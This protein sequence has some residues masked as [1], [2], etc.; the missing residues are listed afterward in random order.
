MSPKAMTDAWRAQ[1]RGRATPLLLLVETDG[2]LFSLGPEG[3]HPAS[4]RVD[5]GILDAL[6]LLLTPADLQETVERLGAVVA[7]HEA[8]GDAPPGIRSAGLFTPHFLFARLPRTAAWPELAAQAPVMIP[9]DWRELLTDLGYE[10]R[11]V[12][13]GYLATVGE[14]EVAVVRAHDDPTDLDAPIDDLDD[15]PYRRLGALMRSHRLSSGMLVARGT[16]RLFATDAVP[17]RLPER[18]LELRLDRLDAAQ[19]PYLGVLAPG[20][21]GREPG[22]KRLLADARQ[23]GVELKEGVEQQIRDVALPSLVRGLLPF[24]GGDPADPEVRREL[25]DAGMTLLFRLVFLL[26]AESA[27]FL[28]VRS[29][30][31]GP[32]SLSRRAAEARRDAPT[33]FDEA[34]TGLWDGVRALVNAIRTGNRSW[35]VSAYNGGLFAPDDFP[36][37][38]LLERAALPDAA[39]GPALVALGYDRAE[40]GDDPP[41]IDWAGLGVAHIGSIYEGLLHLRLAYAERNMAY[42]AGADRYELAGPD[43]PVAQPAGSCFLVSERGGRKAGGVYYTQELFVDHLVEGALAPPLA[44]HLERVREQAAADEDAAASSLLDFAVIDPAMGSGHFLVGALDF[45]AAEIGAFLRDVPLAGIARRIE[46]LRDAAVVGDALPSTDRQLL[47]RLLVKHCVFGVDRS[48]MAVELAKIS[49]WLSSFVPGLPLSVLDA[50]LRHGDSLIGVDRIDRVTVRL[51]LL[52]PLIERPLGEAVREVAAAAERPDSTLDEVAETARAIA[53]ADRAAGTV[54]RLL[55]AYTA[56]AFG[57]RGASDLIDDHAKARA[58]LEGGIDGVGATA[59]AV[60]ALRDQIKFLHWPLAFPRVFAREN[61]GFDAV[62]GNPPWNEVTVERTGF[63]VQ[64]DPG[65]GSVRTAADREQRIAELLARFPELLNDYE[66]AVDHAERLRTFFRST[67]G[68]YALQGAGDLDLYELFCERYGA[69]LRRGG[70]FGVVLPRSAFYV[71]GTVGFRRWLFAVAPPRRLD[72]VLNNRKWAFPIHPQYTIA[73]V[74]GRRLTFRPDA[75]VELSGPHA[76]RTAFEERVPVPVAHGALKRWTQPSRRGGSRPTWEVPLLPAAAARDLY[77]ALMTLPRLDEG[78]RGDWRAFGATD[79]H[80]RNNRQLINMGGSSEVWTGGTFE[81]YEPWF[82]GIAGA[83]DP[84]AGHDFL[85][86]RRRRSPVWRREWPDALRDPDTLPARNYRIAFRDVTN[87]TN[88]RT[89]I[90]C[91]VPPNVF[92]TNTAPYLVLPA[93]GRRAEAYLL[94]VMNSLAFNW[95]ARRMVELHVN[96]FVLNLLR[97]PDVPLD[98]D[99]AA[100]IVRPAAR[101]QATHPAYGAWATSLDVQCGPLSDDERRMLRIEVEAAA[102]RAYGLGADDLDVILDDLTE[103]AWGIDDRRALRAALP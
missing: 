67:M 81:Q 80:V 59:S 99:A 79:F 37:A 16:V 48:A 38:A 8:A 75:L 49:L 70:G 31:Y 50:N 83:C 84:A 61:P 29:E 62:V 66:G 20:T 42:D 27:D 97:V 39:L 71:A 22:I 6:G 17:S 5:A 78:G 54:G 10:L 36:G 103:R 100:A 23:Y 85:E 63:F 56:I 12:T 1:R 32:H 30:R 82:G 95:L 74:A 69:L 41:G 3:T 46:V 77:D 60:E 65:L 90:A 14:E 76:S 33:G 51:G 11:E 53:A 101:L 91:L 72:V 89:V 25:S 44:E 40:R 92:L 28:P 68:D 26:Y 52:A 43:D 7:D 19:R 35:G 34:A 64:H 94:G 15:L 58:L 24:A 86:V 9:R 98:G 45:L 96:F 4:M 47:R 73:L 55:D 102:L 18:Y 93:G 13:D 21:L 87:R 88:S 2:D 57:V